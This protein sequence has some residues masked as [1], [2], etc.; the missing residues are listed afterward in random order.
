VEKK[1]LEEFFG[2][3]V[4]VV[5]ET[6]NTI[7]GEIRKALT[8]VGVPTN[9]IHLEKEID[10]A[11]RRIEQLKPNTVIAEFEHHDSYGLDLIP[12]FHEYSSPE[13]RVFVL[14]SDS[15]DQAA[16]ADAAEEEVD[17][18]VIKPA[19]TEKF[20]K[21]F[22]EVHKNKVSPSEYKTMIDKA[23]TQLREGKLEEAQSTASMSLLMANGKTSMAYYIQGEVARLQ[24]NPSRALE[25][26]QTGLKANPIHYKCLQGKFMALKELDKRDDAYQTIHDISKHF[27]LTP[28]LLLNAFI[29]SVFTYNFTEV[30]NYYDKYLALPRKSDK[31][32]NTVSAALMTSA[33]YLLR[34]KKTQGKAL[35]Y[36]KKGS[37]I[38]GRSPTFLKNVVETLVKHHLTAECDQFLNMF[39]HDE[40]PAELIEQLKFRILEVDAKSDEQIINQGRKLI[41]SEQADLYIYKSIIDRVSGIEAKQG[42]LQTIVDKGVRQFPDERAYF[43]KFMD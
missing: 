15:A 18:F 17:A 31:L 8:E 1:T 32:K 9:N 30:D 38:A 34:E 12:S 21:Y 27:P 22:K 20:V 39:A 4:V 2:Q 40:V 23:K 37:V 33:K 13:D 35:E 11:R 10:H 3:R 43:A 16:V 42:F 36:F 25:F 7:R 24:G 5:Y 26:Y 41:M 28:D 14:T 6:S 19:N 29:Y